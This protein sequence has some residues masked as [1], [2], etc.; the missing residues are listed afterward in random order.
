MKLSIWRSSHLVLAVASLLFILSASITGAILS[1]DPL[2]HSNAGSYDQ[3][4]PVFKTIEAVKSQYLEVFK[5]EKNT[6]GE[7]VA[8]VM[9]EQGNSLQV[10]INPLTGQNL[11]T[12]KEQ[13]TFFKEITAFHRSLF[14]GTAGRWVIV[15]TSICL[16][17]ITITGL[18]LVAQ[19]LGGWLKFLTKVKKDESAPYYHTV[20]GRY[21]FIIILIISVSGILMFLKDYWN[22]ATEVI[23]L[24]PFLDDASRDQE[25]TYAQFKV[26]QVPL[27]DVMKV[28]FPLT[29]DPEDAF[30]IETKKDAAVIHQQTGEI[31]DSY[32]KDAKGNLYT[33]LFNLHTGHNMGYW[34]IILLIACLNIIFFIYSGLLITFKR[35]N[36]KFKNKINAK[37]AEIILFVG[38]EN[39]STWQFA[40]SFHEALLEQGKRIRTVGLQENEHYPKLKEL[41][42]FTSTYGIGEA[43][44]N[45]KN[46]VDQLKNNSFE[47]VSYSILGFGSKQYSDFCQYAFTINDQLKQTPANEFIPIQ[48]VDNKN[49]QQFN[50]WVASYKEKSGLQ[51]L[52][53]SLKLKKH[54]TYNFKVLSNSYIDS[55]SEYFILQIEVNKGFKSGDLISILAPDT[56]F[57]RQYSVAKTGKNMLSIYVKKHELG[58]CSSYLSALKKGDILKGWIQ[59]NENFRLTTHQPVI[60]IGNGTGIAPFIGFE[61]EKKTKDLKIIWG[62]KTK[63]EKALI[64]QI[65]PNYT[66]NWTICYSREAEEKTYASTYFIQNIE[67]YASEIKKGSLLYICGALQMEKDLKK[68]LSDYA[69]QKGF[70]PDELLKNVRS[71]CY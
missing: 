31:V 53:A 45:G 4:Q 49:I 70:S 68:A 28:E 10:L 38:S 65:F 21:S 19:K 18:F 47:N 13:S 7:W 50:N 17:L 36:A 23:E 2:S 16:T 1:F 15:I 58:W 26:F 22:P 12:P 66:E 9:D 39:G 52:N 61:N 40:K 24:D 55:S 25:L 56:T 43:P 48:T 35:W 41:I 42:I 8:D 51:N 46:F 3:N 27:S 5:L 62:T 6:Y 71:D 44:Y 33:F 57:A 64:E 60:A 67:S 54:K 20:L 11:G 37:D 34:P 14:M 59:R 30:I 29:P 63:Q 32:Q 69:I